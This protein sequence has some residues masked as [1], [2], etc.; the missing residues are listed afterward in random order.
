MAKPTLYA[1]YLSLAL[2][3][4]LYQTSLFA[5]E[6]QNSA[7]AEQISVPQQELVS[8]NESTAEQLSSAMNGV[9][10]KKHRPLSV[11]ANNMALSPQ[12]NS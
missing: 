12:L 7:Q 1:L 5:A 3:G 9:G 4:S 6:A 11:I 2:G 10:L 8:I